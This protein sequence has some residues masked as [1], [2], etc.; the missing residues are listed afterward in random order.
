MPEAHVL[1]IGQTLD[2]T[3]RRGRVLHYR[4]PGMRSLARCGQTGDIIVVNFAS[5]V[6]CRR[7]LR[8]TREGTRSRDLD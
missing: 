5:M 4:W 2:P 8:L 6:T 7:C 1:L 3:V